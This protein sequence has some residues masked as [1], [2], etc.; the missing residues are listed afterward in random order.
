MRLTVVGPFRESEARFGRPVH[1][2]HSTAMNLGGVVVA[3][4]RCL[5]SLIGV[6]SSRRQ[7]G[8]ATWRRRTSK[9]ARKTRKRVCDGRESSNSSRAPLPF[10]RTTFVA[11]TWAAAN[12]AAREGNLSLYSLYSRDD[13]LTVA[14]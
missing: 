11:A 13:D 3:R 12:L 14:E 1:V 2:A 10:P 9:F 4:R 6:K 7:G 8:L 5:V